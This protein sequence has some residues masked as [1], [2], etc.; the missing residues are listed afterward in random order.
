[1]IDNLLHREELTAFARRQARPEIY[2]RVQ[3]DEITQAESEG[4]Q[5]KRKSRKSAQVVRPRPK[6]GAF[7]ARV[8]TLM[9]RL[10]FDYL[11]GDGGA[12]LDVT[13]SDPETPQTQLD[14][15]AVDAEVAVHIEC[16]TF[17]SPRKDPSFSQKLAKHALARRRFSQ[18]ISK[19]VPQEQKRHV[20]SIFFTWDVVLTPN[21]AKRAKEEN[22]VLLDEHDLRYFEALVGHL[23]PAARYQFLATVFPGKRIPGLELTV[24]ALRTKVGNTTCYTFA[25]RPEYLLKIIYVSHR[26]Q[27][28]ATDIDAYQR[29]ISKTRLARIADYIDRE[30]GV[31]PTNI[32]INIAERYYLQF[33]RA[34]QETDDGKGG[35]FGWLTLRP[36]YGC[37]WVID[38]QH[39]LFAYSG[40][41]R[42][43]TSF[44]H[45]LAFE[46]LPASQQAKLF[47]DIN[48]EQRRV[49][50]SLLVELDADLKWDSTDEDERITA[51][52]SKAVMALDQ[53]PGSPFYRRILPADEKRTDV[54]CISLT[55]LFGA[56]DRA[57]LYVIKRKGGITEYGP[58]WAGDNMATLRRTVETLTAW[59]NVI[60][61]QNMEWWDAGSSADGGLAMNNPVTICISVLRSVLEHLLAKNYRVRLYDTHDLIDLLAPWAEAVA[62]YFA[63][64]DHQRR[65][66]L[67]ALQGSQG[68]IAG[69][70][71]CLIDLKKKFPEF[72]PP[73]LS[74]EI[75]LQEART[76]ERAFTTIDRIEK[77]LKKIILAGL[78]DEF[79]GDEKWWFEGVPTN[80]RKKVSERIEDD[81]GEMGGRED[82]FDLIDFRAIASNN[83]ET[84]QDLLSFESTGSKDKRTEWIAKVNEMRKIVMHPAKGRVIS[85][86]QL[87]LLETYLQW[88]ESKARGE[89]SPITV[90]AQ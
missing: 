66:E 75:A 62:A 27:G 54:R 41:R 21:D 78:K 19:V 74:E 8:W 71:M 43:A 68:Q 3:K 9:Y 20:G 36:A 90:D 17:E 85:F 52:I 6:P 10:G 39:R 86:E 1:M 65:V 67:R 76:N 18:S 48:S 72:D 50:R 13:P 16:K 24:P 83:W 30:G 35:T 49:K 44:L 70:R 33:D 58:L 80:V 7:E 26:A 56:L 88:L 81:K 82:Y 40:H 57:G 69:T 64:M 38:G 47:V 45:V 55:G 53:D 73:G 89:I 87:R 31:F 46:G 2:K 51:I 63:G 32:V 42:A 60:R 77:L 59:F 14:I 84:F 12:H 25:M 29:M 79:P 61:A 37:A 28:K 5:L 4:W 23:G 15:V 34:K 11:S 22:V